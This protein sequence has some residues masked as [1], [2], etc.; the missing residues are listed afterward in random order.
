M[1][2]RHNDPPGVSAGLRVLSAFQCPWPASHRPSLYFCL[3]LFDQRPRNSDP[4]RSFAPFAL[5]SRRRP[6][7][8]LTISALNHELSYMRGPVL[9]LL[10][11]PSAAEG[12]VPLIVRPYDIP[13]QRWR[14]PYLLVD[15]IPK[16]RWGHEYVY[17][18]P[19]VHNRNGFD[20]YSLGPD[21][22][23]KTGGDDPDDVRTWR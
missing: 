15:K 5:R 12:L 10:H 6:R 4:L 1:E 17:R 8:P 14:G 22:K 3:H 9:I 20:I 18:F 21:G 13:E 16:D 11:I 7:S 19:G 23:S 2:S